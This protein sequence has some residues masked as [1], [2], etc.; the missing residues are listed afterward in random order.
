MSTNLTHSALIAS[1]DKEGSGIHSSMFC[2]EASLD[3]E[4]YM[5][6][7]TAADNEA[8]YEVKCEEEED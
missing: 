2:F 1:D 8:A 7:A 3:A 6:Y 4:R 5:G